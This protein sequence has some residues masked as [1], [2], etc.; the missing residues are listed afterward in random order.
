M[1]I[2]LSLVWIL[3]FYK[4][5]LLLAAEEC[6]EWAIEN[7]SD[8]YH[9]LITEALEEYQ[10]ST[11]SG[12]AEETDAETEGNGDPEFAKNYVGHMLGLILMYKSL[13]NYM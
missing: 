10:K 11:V 12:K 6:G 13:H 9:S 5:D 1:Y 7:I 2:V 4:D 8:E 3:A